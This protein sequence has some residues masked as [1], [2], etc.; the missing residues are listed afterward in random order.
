MKIQII[1]K[2][3]KFLGE[4]PQIKEEFEIVYL[5]VELRK[6]LDRERGRNHQN[7]DSL[8]RFH[9]DWTL[10]TDKRKITAP[11]KEIMKKIDDSIDTYPKDGNIDFLLLPEFRAELIKLLEEHGL[12]NDFCIKDENWLVF[13][14]TLTQV[15]SDQPIINPT[16]NITEFRYV[17]IKR[18]GIMAN[19]DFGGTKAGSSITLGF[20]M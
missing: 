16:D 1:E 17:D 9:A 3:D 8:V 15:L 11:M 10:H 19:I 6:L 14:T 18:K 20:G 12:P 4:R 13:I 2:L 7:Q 5:M